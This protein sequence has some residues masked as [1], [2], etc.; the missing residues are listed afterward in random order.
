[1][2]MLTIHSHQ[3]AMASKTLFKAFTSL[4]RIRRYMHT[5]HIRSIRFTFYKT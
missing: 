4:H 1:M 2:A 5:V 3:E